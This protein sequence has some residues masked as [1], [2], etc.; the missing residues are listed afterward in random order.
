MTLLTFP[1]QPEGISESL[2]VSN[3]HFSR[4]PLS[5]KWHLVVL[6]K[7]DFYKKIFCEILGTMLFMFFN[8]IQMIKDVF[9]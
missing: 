3:I 7:Y 1:T 4:T 8:K 5:L 2:L 9:K 6:L